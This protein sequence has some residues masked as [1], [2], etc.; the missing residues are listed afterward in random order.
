MIFATAWGGQGADDAASRSQGSRLVDYNHL[1]QTMPY[2]TAADRS[3][4]AEPSAPDTEKER[5]HEHAH[6]YVQVCR[7][8]T[9]WCV[10]DCSHAKGARISESP[11]A[12][13]NYGANHTKRKWGACDVLA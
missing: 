1:L 12:K 4:D 7:Q 3:E 11:A 6:T 2:I 13:R 5:Y 8:D 10:T 9:R